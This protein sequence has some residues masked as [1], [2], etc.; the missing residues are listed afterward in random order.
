MVRRSRKIPD[1]GMA[2]PL[3]TDAFLDYNRMLEPP[4]TV[5]GTSRIEPKEKP[6]RGHTSTTL[7]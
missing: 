2:F 5:N 4:V 3:K 1:T 6:R 7:L